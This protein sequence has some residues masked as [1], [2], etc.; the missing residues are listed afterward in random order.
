M[1]PDPAGKFCLKC[2]IYLFY[3]GKAELH[4]AV[5]LISVLY[6]NKCVS[7]LSC[8][9]LRYILSEKKRDEHSLFVSCKTAKVNF[10]E[11]IFDRE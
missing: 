2:Y 4:Q 7:T 9:D 11:G 6:H 5:S 8:G 10:Q 3:G 1:L